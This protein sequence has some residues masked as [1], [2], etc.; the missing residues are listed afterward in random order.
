MYKTNKGRLVHNR[1]KIVPSAMTFGE[2]LANAFAAKVTGVS[3]DLG[4]V[5]EIITAEN[6]IRA[7]V[8]KNK[9]DITIKFLRE[10]ACKVGA[11]TSNS[12]SELFLDLLKDAVKFYSCGCSYIKVS[13][14]DT[15][16]DIEGIMLGGNK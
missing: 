1:V 15:G 3:K 7:L 5:S 6:S 13:E 10:A 12:A 2:A 9:A 14:T 4:R 11:R 16:V 8:D